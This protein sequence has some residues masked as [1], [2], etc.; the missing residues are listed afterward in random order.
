MSTVSVF[1]ICIYRAKQIED[2]NQKMYMRL[3]NILTVSLF[4][5]D[6]HDRTASHLG[7]GALVQQL[8]TM[9]IERIQSTRLMKKT[10]NF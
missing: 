1:I 2:E 6:N 4:Y 9:F 10:I 8:S 3:K 7:R 5:R